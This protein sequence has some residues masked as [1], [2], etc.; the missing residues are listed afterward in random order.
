MKNWQDLAVVVVLVI[1]AVVIG[2]LIMFLLEGYACYGNNAADIT[3]T[4]WT[5]LVFPCNPSTSSSLSLLSLS[6]SAVS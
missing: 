2:G 4:D 5:A 3:T 6:S 1:V